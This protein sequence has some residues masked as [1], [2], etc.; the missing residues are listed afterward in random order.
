MGERLNTP[1][2]TLVTQEARNA[3][4]ND[5]VTEHSAS[6]YKWQTWNKRN[7]NLYDRSQYPWRCIPWNI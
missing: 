1:Y 5:N 4:F 3:S 6:N 2:T 7:E